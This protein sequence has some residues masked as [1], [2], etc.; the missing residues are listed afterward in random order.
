MS[1][2]NTDLAQLYSHQDF[3]LKELDEIGRDRLMEVFMAS[4]LKNLNSLLL[5]EQMIAIWSGSEINGLRVCDPDRIQFRARFVFPRVL[6]PFDF[7]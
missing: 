6:T 2:P 1:A 5:K 7:T 4:F 3:S